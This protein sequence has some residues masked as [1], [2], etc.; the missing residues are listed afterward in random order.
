M[1]SL[2]FSWKFSYGFSYL[3]CVK[4]TRMWVFTDPYIPDEIVDSAHI[5]ARENPY[6]DKFYAVLI[7]IAEVAFCWKLLLLSLVI[8]TLKSYI[9][10]F[11]WFFVAAV[12]EKAGMLVS[13]TMTNSCL[14]LHPTGNFM[15]KVNNKDTRATS[16]T[17]FW[18]LYC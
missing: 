8:S 10:T 6:F 18:C 16:L 9:Q 3:H 12:S 4:F 2:D 5:R 1:S 14:S 13:V 15:F 7:R 11:W 17:L